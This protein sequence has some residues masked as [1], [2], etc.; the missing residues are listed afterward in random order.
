MAKVDLLLLS[1]LT[2][3]DGSIVA[4][5]ATLKF[6]SEFR[7]GSTAI[8]VQPKLYRNREL[9]ESGYTNTVMPETLIP[10]NFILTLSEEEY[11]VLTPLDLYEKVGEWLNAFMGGNYFQLEIINE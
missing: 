6:D 8:Q 2:A 11:Y 10:Y 4:S 3:S 1:G 9:F 7:A 5:G